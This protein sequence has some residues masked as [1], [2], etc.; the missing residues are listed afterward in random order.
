MNEFLLK[1]YELVQYSRTSTSTSTSRMRGFNQ[2][3]GGRVTPAAVLSFAMIGVI[4]YVL[5]AAFVMELTP[6]EG[7]T[8]DICSQRDLFLYICA[9]I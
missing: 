5:S 8:F 6:G 3:L 7:D 9:H 1:N 2:L 4:V